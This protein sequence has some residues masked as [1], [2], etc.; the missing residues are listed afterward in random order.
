MFADGSISNDFLRYMN[1]SIALKPLCY[2]N[3]YKPTIRLT[4]L[5]YIDAVMPM[6]ERLLFGVMV[7]CSIYVLVLQLCGY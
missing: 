2:K 5:P 6:A 3:Y 1:L 4:T 7:Y